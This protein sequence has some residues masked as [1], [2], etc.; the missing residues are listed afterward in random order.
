MG[1]HGVCLAD[2]II[3]GPL[4]EKKKRRGNRK[5]Q[6]TIQK[7]RKSIPVV[8]NKR[9]ILNVGK[10]RTQF[11]GPKERKARKACQKA[12]MVFRSVVFALTSLTK[13]QSRTFT[14]TKAEERIKQEKAKKEPM[15]ASETL[16]EAGYD[17]ACESDDWSSSHWTDHSWTPDA[18][19]FCTK[20]HTA[21]M[22]ATLLNLV[23]HP[24][25]VILD[26]GCTRSI[27]SRAAIERFKK[28]A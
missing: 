2:Q 12:V 8:M 16:S 13:V 15:S 1:R 11:G 23:N 9:K 17:R 6:S 7:D 19:W 18:G 25:H 27:G 22:S 21:W 20:T 14:K 4:D 28:H 10:K 5:R 26:L 3:Q 24:T